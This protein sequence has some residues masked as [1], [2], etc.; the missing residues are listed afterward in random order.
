MKITPMFAWFDFW[1]GWYWDREA[2]VLYVF[3]APMFGVRIE[4]KRASK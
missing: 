1:I 3:P 4:R 2:K